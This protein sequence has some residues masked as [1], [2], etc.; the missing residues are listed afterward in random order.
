MN[1]YLPLPCRG[2]SFCAT[3]FLSWLTRGSLY[4]RH[5]FFAFDAARL[6]ARHPFGF[7]SRRL[8]KA[9]HG[10]VARRDAPPAGTRSVHSCH[11]RRAL[12][13]LLG[14][15]IRRARTALPV[16]LRADKEKATRLRSAGS[17]QSA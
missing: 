14:V 13:D 5:P 1:Y 12:M 17:G 2:A 4:A 3:T 9:F 16:S 15:P 8:M 10:P 11:G 6:Y 7:D